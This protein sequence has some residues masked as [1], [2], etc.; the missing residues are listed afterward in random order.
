MTAAPGSTPSLLPAAPAKGSAWHRV[1]GSMTRQEWLRVGGMA[2]VIV[3][4]HV[5]GW[6]TLIA[7]VA[8]HHYSI[9]EKSFGIGIGVTAYTLGMRHAFDADHIAAIDNT[10]RK[11]M[12]EGQRPLSVGFWF[13]LGHS[14]VV[15]ALALLLSLGV[16]TLAGPVRDDGSGLHD[17]TGLIGTTVS[18]TFL[19]IIAAINLVILAGIWKVFRQM[20]SGHYDEAALEEQLNNRGF[21]N[22]LL[23]RVMKSITKS[24]QMYPLGL[25][26]GLGFDTATEIALL[27]LAGSGAASGL[28]WYAILCLPVLFAA[29]MSLLDTID[30]SFMNFAYGWAFSKPVRKVYYNLT[31]TGL[32]V[33]VALLIG[34]VELLGLLVDRLGLHGPFWD[35]IAG[36]DLNVLGFVIVGLFF[37]TWIVA[38]IVWKVGRIEEKWSAGLARPA[39]GAEEGA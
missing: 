23:G 9:G 16:K 36:L 3:A 24:W 35:W 18:G 17:V 22:R 14:S 32:S 8:P 13:S 2:A 33:A 38:L 25:L 31:I 27:V 12:G 39:A 21:M 26:F 30:G 11:L 29:G 6:F 20:R 15:F 34:T 4:L 1:R 37:A 7:I 19:Y 10:T 28:P 5:I